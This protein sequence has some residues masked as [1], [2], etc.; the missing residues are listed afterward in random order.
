MSKRKSLHPKRKPKVDAVAIDT[1]QYHYIEGSWK[2]KE[3]CGC[4]GKKTYGA[5]LPNVPSMERLLT[6]T[7]TTAGVVTAPSGNSYL[8]QLGQ[9]A[10]DM[11]EA[12]YEFFKLDTRFRVV[13]SAER[14]QYVGVN[15]RR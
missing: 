5:A 9:V 11:E 1:K 12:D 3:G 6:F 14:A 7:Q 2:S 15:A 10:L 4:G 8:M 13:A